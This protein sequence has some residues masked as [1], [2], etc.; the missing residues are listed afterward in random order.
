MPTH[1]LFI[2][3][4]L[5]APLLDTLTGV[6]QRLQRQLARYPLRWVRPEGIHLTLKFLGETDAARIDDL[7]HALQAVATHYTAFELSV[8]GLGM[9]PH[10]RRPSVL[11]V[12]VQDEQHRLQKLA[13]DIDKAVAGLGWKPEKKPFT[14]H[15]TLA[16]VKRQAS[17]P[18]R[19]ALGQ[20]VAGLRGYARVGVLPVQR[21]CIMRS[22]LRAGGAVYT[23]V[24][25]VTLNQS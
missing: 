2:A 20:Q 17:N 21:V 11:W 14:G 23:E 16:R 12:G 13:A 6:Q 5:P 8:G 19:R 15:L 24:A 25:C 10:A 4:T 7:K 3:I 22:Q 18:Q 9:F 1:R